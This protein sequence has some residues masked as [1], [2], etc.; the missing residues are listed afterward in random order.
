MRMRRRKKGDD[1]DLYLLLLPGAAA[2]A[3]LPR[4]SDCATA[5]ADSTQHITTICIGVTRLTKSSDAKTTTGGN[6]HINM[7]LISN[8]I[9][10]M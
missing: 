3:P 9:H 8:N 10:S 4:L 5:A 6:R 1:V 2:E 7:A